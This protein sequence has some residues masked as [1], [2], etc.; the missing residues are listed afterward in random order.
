MIYLKDVFR[1]VYFIFFFSLF[2]SMAVPHWK[3]IQ[4][5]FEISKQI[6]AQAFGGF[7]CFFGH[8]NRTPKGV[9]GVKLPSLRALSGTVFLKFPNV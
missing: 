8:K 9:S 5:D 7:W 2:P 1:F 3:I 6:K 4:G